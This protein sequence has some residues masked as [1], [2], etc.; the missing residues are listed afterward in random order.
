[1]FQTLSCADG[2]VVLTGAGDQSQ[3]SAAA[4]TVSLSET[5]VSSATVRVYGVEVFGFPLGDGR[6]RDDRK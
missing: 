6:T 5:L 4:R 1:M 3:A 2:E